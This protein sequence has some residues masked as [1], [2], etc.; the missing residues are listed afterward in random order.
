VRAAES[1]PRVLKAALGGPLP[2]TGL[3]AR[4]VLDEL[5]ERAA[6]GIVASQ[7]PRYFGF[8]VG[9][10]V[11]A[12]LV[13]DWMAAA[14]DQNAAGYLLSPA[15]GVLQEIVGDWCKE[16][17]G[18]PRHA[19]HGTVTGTQ[20]AH[21]TCLAVARH[22]VLAGVGWD[23]EA[24]GLVGAPRIR[25]LVGEH[26][27]V[28]IDRAAQLLG[29]GTNALVSVEADDQGRMRPDALRA[30]L[31]A[32]AGPVIVCLQAGEVNTGAFD[33][34]VPLV[35][36]AHAAGAWVHVDGAFGLWAAA[37]SRHRHS[38]QGAA[39]ADS[40]A[41]DGHKWLN[42][43][44]DSGL[45]FTAHPDSH[46]AAMA[47]HAAYLSRARAGERDEDDWT[48]DFSRRSRAIAL[49]AALRSLGREGVAEIVERCCD[50]AT[51]FAERLGGEHEVEVLNDVML[52]QVLVR[53]GGDDATTDRVIAAV[54]SDGT[55]WM[56]GTTW[57][58]RRAMRVSVTNW[59][60]T[61]DDVD[62]SVEAI[63]RC[64]RTAG[65]V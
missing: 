44:Y 40:W 11:P 38:V 63:F 27:H 24:D 26:R 10:S 48:P 42:V 23:A 17:L 53:F 62:R 12:S 2:E 31:A 3:A 7:S 43:P 15:S 50:C 22:H 64:L 54:Q 6:P 32:G 16:L 59:A 25:V 18:L 58:G 51:R 19:S 4:L 39:G 37:S 57:K 20:M 9:G 36:A 49:Y 55:C 41:T 60:T 45:L 8:V 47:S 5:V 21:L 65:A 56:S 46:R 52:N 14:W 29:L 61:S 30:A 13:A 34:F 35:E 1:D 28:T 33:P